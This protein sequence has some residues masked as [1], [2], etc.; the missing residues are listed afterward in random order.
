[1]TQVNVP[2]FAQ[3]WRTAMAASVEATGPGIMIMGVRN[4]VWE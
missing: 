3:A 4:D 1:M 2:T